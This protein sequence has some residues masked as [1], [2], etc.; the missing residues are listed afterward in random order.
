MLACSITSLCEV[1]RT[2]AKNKSMDD[3]FF[4]YRHLH[5]PDPHLIN[6]APIRNPWSLL[7]FTNFAKVI[8]SFKMVNFL[9]HHQAAHILHPRKNESFDEIL[10]AC[11]KSW[12]KSWWW[13]SYSKIEFR[14]TIMSNWV[15]LQS[16]FKRINL[17]SSRISPTLLKSRPL[18]KGVKLM[19]RNKVPFHLFYREN[20]SSK[21]NR[22]YM[23]MGKTRDLQRGHDMWW[24][25]AF[26]E[27]GG[28][29]YSR[30]GGRLEADGS[31]EIVVISLKSLLCTPASSFS[32]YFWK[33]RF[34]SHYEWLPLPTQI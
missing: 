21:D 27:R 34:H 17:H 33:S 20:G 8:L 10:P 30:G 2:M 16:Y 12:W 5:R 11:L 14:Y 25:F 31:H 3:F 18:L 26:P 22:H 9:M 19:E 13:L 32:V 28:L 4:L 6:N 29:L 1:S 24:D 23:M 7:T 15:L